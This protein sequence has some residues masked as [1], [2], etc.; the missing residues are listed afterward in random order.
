MEKTY[1]KKFSKYLIPSVISM[2]LLAVYTF[3]DSFVI[4]QKLGSTALGAMGICTPVVTLTY[5]LGYL[6]GK[7][8]AA[9]YSIATGKNNVSQAKAIH[10]TSVVS[11]LAF[12]VL[13]SIVLNIFISPLALFLGA[14]SSNIE[15]VIP[16]LR[17]IL[18]AIPAL[19]ME[20][21][22]TCYVNNDGQPKLAM[23]ATIIGVVSNV[24]LD[25]VFVFAFNWGMFG[26]AFAT[27]LCSF[28]G[29][30]VKL[31]YICTKSE[32]L[33]P[34]LKYVKLNQLSKILGSGFSSM[35]L[36]SSA[37]IVTF[38]Y[39]S[40]SIKYYGDS[41]SVIY[42][43]ILNWSLIAVNLVIGVAEAAQPLLSLS[44]GAGDKKGVKAYLRCSLI[45]SLLMGVL[46]E[47]I[48]YCFT[49]QLVTVFASDNAELV[50]VITG[51][52]RLYLPSF[53]FMVASIC[54]GSSFQATG[55]AV[56]SFVIMLLRGI[57][58]PVVFAVIFPCL[59]RKVSLWVSTPAA[60]LIASL[61]AITLLLLSA[62]SADSLFSE[63]EAV[64]VQQG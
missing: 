45:V 8:G 42:T 12:G 36:E 58:L 63:R 3:T 60:E 18:V 9:L 16:Y 55:K 51:C 23:A 2:A 29:T 41:G 49:P 39:I 33:K 6:F 59:F 22:T 46:F 61:S 1:L 4:G 57:L 52:L 50:E 5:A 14:D 30:L 38:V 44:F 43:V 26:A 40:Q 37:A 64:P 56:Q 7:G 21:S 28:L 15:Y 62:K 24:I 10:N 47:L 53:L 31:T 48:G 25:F 32:G 11:M 35:I 19:M 27:V 54:I 20:I 13:I 34:S 17:V